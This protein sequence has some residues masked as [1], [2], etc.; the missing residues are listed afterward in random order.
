MAPTVANSRSS[1]IIGERCFSQQYALPLS[2]ARAL[3]AWPRSAPRAHASV[4]CPA[5]KLCAE[6]TIERRPSARRLH[7]AGDDPPDLVRRIFL[8]EMDPRDCH[9][10]LR[11]QPAGEVENRTA[12]ENPAGLG[13]HE[14]L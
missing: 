11:W 4:T 3:L 10:G 5:R 1:E 13:L 2:R 7:P 9:L 6:E 8:D 12:G 14:Q